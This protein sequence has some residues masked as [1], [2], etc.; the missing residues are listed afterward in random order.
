M[1]YTVVYDS[2][3]VQAIVNEINGYDHTGTV[4]KGV[5][6]IFGMNFQA[7]SVG[8]K[9]TADGYVDAAGTPRAGLAQALDFVDV[10]LGRFLD[11]LKSQ[12]L[13]NDTLVIVS[14]KHGQSPIDVTQLHMKSGSKNPKATADVTDVTDVLAPLV[15]VAQATEDDISLI[16]LQNSSQVGTAVS[17]LTAQS[18][19][20]RVQTIYSGNSLVSL[21]GDP[22]KDSRTPDLIVQPIPGTIYSKSAAKIAEHGGFAADDTHTALIVSNPR[23]EA[24]SVSRPV[25]NEQVAPTILKALGLPVH[26]LDA[27]RLEGTRVLPGLDLE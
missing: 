12:H 27:V 11:A 6:A 24:A 22:L 25:T 17:L 23:L 4:T 9:L 13:L 2:L 19:A 3:K 7:V 20:A 16:W 21:F 26:A 18:A 10:S 14:A 5:P 15:T 1:S 8:E